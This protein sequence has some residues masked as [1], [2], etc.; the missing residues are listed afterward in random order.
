MDKIE[1]VPIPSPGEPSPM[2][3]EAVV[4]GIPTPPIERIRLFGDRQW[5]E[6]VLEWVDAL[7]TRYDRVER[8]GGPGDMGRDVIGFLS[9]EHDLWDNYQCKHYGAPLAP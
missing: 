7:R 3:P 8:C 6:F 1:T 9:S 2:S 4:S 5:E